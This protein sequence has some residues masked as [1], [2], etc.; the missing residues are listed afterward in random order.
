MHVQDTGPQGVYTGLNCVLVSA[1]AY[2]VNL[3]EF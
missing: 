3:S 1:R 2:G